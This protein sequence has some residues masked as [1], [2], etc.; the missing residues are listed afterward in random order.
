MTSNHPSL[1]I[2]VTSSLVSYFASW[3]NL[4]QVAHCF[5][6]RYPEWLLRCQQNIHRLWMRT[7]I[8]VSSTLWNMLY[9]PF[10]LLPFRHSIHHHLS[11]S[12]HL[13]VPRCTACSWLG[14]YFFGFQTAF[15][16]SLTFQTILNP[17]GFRYPL[18]FS[19]IS[20]YILALKG[21]SSAEK[22]KRNCW[23]LGKPSSSPK[24]KL[25]VELWL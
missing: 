4:Y 17:V 19:P 6:I 7:L 15:R 22:Q 13:L 5:L 23:T 3:S 10:P 9:V 14:H 18:H 25:S 11:H 2:S 16:S 24:I 21:E 8:L 12:S 20:H 1:L